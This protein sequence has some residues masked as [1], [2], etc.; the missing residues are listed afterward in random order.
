M[1]QGPL[2][3]AE[4]HCRANPED[5]EPEVVED[6]RTS[7]GE[8]QLSKSVTE[9]SRGGN[10]AGIG[11]EGAPPDNRAGGSST[12]QPSSGS[13]T[14]K[15]R[16]VTSKRMTRARRR[17]AELV[18]RDGEARRAGEMVIAEQAV[19]ELAGQDGGGCRAR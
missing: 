16:S 8:G 14:G 5:I 9:G 3:M 12:R 19:V 10:R 7:G 11:D 17:A 1:L 13:S 15:P 6:D 4:G 2:A 18:E